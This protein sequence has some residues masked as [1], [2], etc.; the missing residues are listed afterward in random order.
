LTTVLAEDIAGRLLSADVSEYI[1]F[2]AVCKPWRELTD[3]PHEGDG[4]D[5][6]F[7]PRLWFP[8]RKR[9]ATPWHCSFVNNKTGA[10]IGFDHQIFFTSHLLSMVDG[11]LVLCDRATHTVRLLQPLTGAVAVLPDITDVRPHDGAEPSSRLAMDAFKARFPG[12]GTE[13]TAYVSQDEYENCYPASHAVLTSADIDE[14]TSPPTIQLCVR[15][16]SWLVLRAKPEDEHWI[17][18]YPQ[19]DRYNNRIA[20][21]RY[22]Y[23]C[24]GVPWLDRSLKAQPNL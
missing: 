13:S 1:R 14:S 18:M 6:R 17:A 23:R 2:R 20:M 3:D 9:K 7:R 21:L 12:I 4:L 24:A 11:L 22:T 10:R 19:E 16:E 15:D 8:L 5:S